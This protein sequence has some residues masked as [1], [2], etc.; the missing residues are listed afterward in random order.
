MTRK[1][2]SHTSLA[3]PHVHKRSQSKEGR[4]MT[5][6]ASKI[7]HNKKQGKKIRTVLGVCVCVRVCVCVCVCVCA[8]QMYVMGVFLH[9]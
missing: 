6:R 2:E 9:F 7:V 4:E 1:R 5:S 3:D 8:R